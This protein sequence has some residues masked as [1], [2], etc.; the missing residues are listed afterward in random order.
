MESKLWED[1]GAGETLPAL[2]LPITFKTFVL[3]VAGTRDWNPFHHQAPFTRAATGAPDIWLNTM[4]HQSVFARFVTDWLGPESDFRATSIHMVGRIHPGNRVRIEGSVT[5]RPERDGDRLAEIAIMASTDASGVVARA[6]ATMAMP[7]R[8][9][10]PVRP[11]SVLAKPRVEPHPELPEFAR[12]WLG[13]QT[14]PLPGGYPVSEAQI[15]YWAD[16]AQDAN[17]LYA[18]TAYARA[19]R[20]GG[21]IAPLPSLLI[22]ACARAGRMGNSYEHPDCEDP[23]STPW[24][25]RESQRSVSGMT[26]RDHRLLGAM[27]ADEWDPPGCPELAANLVV[28]EYGK[29]LRPGDRV[30]TR[31]ELVN[32]SPLAKTRMGE[33]YF[34]TSLTSFY[35]Q[36][37]EL[38]MVCTRVGLMSKS[39]EHG[40]SNPVVTGESPAAPPTA[41]E[42]ARA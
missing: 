8:A 21:M 19:S 22:W 16:M 13:R 6:T 1:V 3:A 14:D 2:E 40:G 15:M 20:H 24:P 37:D 25:P 10:G 17:P 35:N 12:V 27:L 30:N 18:D 7:S 38:I 32:C 42:E 29:P 34:Q 41:A 28:Q 33:G 31:A 36:H 9:G 4:W 26:T 23:A 5:G 11:R 39:P